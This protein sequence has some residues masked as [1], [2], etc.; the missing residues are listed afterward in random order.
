MFDN[1]KRTVL[2][3]RALVTFSQEWGQVQTV[4]HQR[5]GLYIPTSGRVCP[6]TP[7]TDLLKIDIPPGFW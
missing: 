3:V 4:A 5:S 6:S 2:L 7:H 1:E